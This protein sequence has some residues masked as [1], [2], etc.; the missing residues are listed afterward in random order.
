MLVQS[1]E[2]GTDI[3]EG[4]IELVKNFVKGVAS[5]VKDGA[6]D[7]SKTVSTA[8]KETSVVENAF[9]GTAET[10]KNVVSLK[11]KKLLNLL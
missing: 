4:V 7:T 3:V 5:T 6:E 10:L 1:S 9:D 2:Q 11:P 8:V